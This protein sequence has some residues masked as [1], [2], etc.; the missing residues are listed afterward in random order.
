MADDQPRG[1]GN[2]ALYWDLENVHVSL[3]HLEAASGATARGLV[4]M[5]AV[6]EFAAA[7]GR[8]VIHRAYANWNALAC[9]RTP[10]LDHAVDLVQLFHPGKSGKN[11]ADIRLALDVMEDLHHFPHITHVVIVS[12]DSDFLAVAQ[13]V[14]RPGRMIAGVGVERATNPYWVKAC[15]AFT[16]HGALRGMPVVAPVA[17]A[18]APRAPP[19]SKVAAAG[20][21][22]SARALPV[23]AVDALAVARG[24]PFVLKATLRPMMQQ[25]DPAFNERHLGF[26]SF[27]AFLKTCHDVVRVVAGEYDHMVGLA[28]PEPADASIPHA[29]DVEPSRPTPTSPPP[30]PRAAQDAPIWAQAR[31]ASA[32]TSGRAHA[33]ARRAA[34]TLQ[35]RPTS[36]WTVFTAGRVIELCVH[37]VGPIGLGAELPAAPQARRRTVTASIFMPR[38]LRAA[39]SVTA[40]RRESTRRV[41]GARFFSTL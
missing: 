37:P 6:V 15:D 17:P 36:T 13:K 7:F 12:G 9:Y 5:D 41:P 25:L 40:A 18:P 27:T 1:G 38:G 10:L 28:T 2:V 21:L 23:R 14:R 26:A 35:S 22:D 3:G 30:A 34:E 24:E 31:S 11:G 39:G 20:E 8:V 32:A 29:S 16:F 19:A 4:D 33:T